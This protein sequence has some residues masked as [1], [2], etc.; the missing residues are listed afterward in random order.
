[1]LSYEKIKG[2]KVDFGKFSILYAEDEAGISKNISS[3]LGLY[4]KEVFVAKDG[5]ELLNLYRLNSPDILLIDICMPNLNGLDAL[6]IIRKNDVK[7]PV[8]VV[9]AHAETN[10]LL[11]AVELF[12]AKFITKPFDKQTLFDALEAALKPKIKEV[13][14]LTDNV[15]Y[16]YK[17]KQ[18]KIDENIISLNKKES[19]LI[20][21]LLSNKGEIVSVSDIENSVYEGEIMSDDALKS[22]LKNL[23]KKIGSDIIVNKKG[24]GY[25]IYE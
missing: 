7:T 10:Y 19:L 4:F 22:L 23:R 1:M 25:I 11:K 24:L 3:L 21:L 8:V 17:N 2:E 16:I 20:E 13:V 12:I 15:A 9:T 5:I 18:I 14:N 6:K